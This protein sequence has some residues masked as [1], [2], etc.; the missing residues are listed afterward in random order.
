MVPAVRPIPAPILAVGVAIT[1]VAIAGRRHHVD[2]GR[3]IGTPVGVPG[4]SIVAAIVIAVPLRGIDSFA[5]GISI[6]D[7]GPS[8]EPECGAPEECSVSPVPSLRLAGSE[9]NR[10]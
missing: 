2:V 9:G 8:Q 6:R 1:V 7:R 3:T 4:L 5:A 10:R